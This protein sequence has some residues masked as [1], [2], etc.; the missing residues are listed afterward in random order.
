MQGGGD[1]A[2]G[3]DGNWHQSWIDNNGGH[4]Q[5][6]GGLDENGVMVLQSQWV[7]FTDRA[8]NKRKTR[9]RWHWAPQED[10][11]IHNWGSQQAELPQVTDWVKYY[12]IIYRPNVTGGPTVNVNP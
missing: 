2:I 12:D 7:E 1:S 8:G 6:S 9:H 3:P 10:G 4:I 11:T 5:L